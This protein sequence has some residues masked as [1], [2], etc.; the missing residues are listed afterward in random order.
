MVLKWA[1]RQLRPCAPDVDARGHEAVEV[2]LSVGR[3]V[4][5]GVGRLIVLQCGDLH[6]RPA[7]LA[8]SVGAADASTG[9]LRGQVV[10]QRST[11]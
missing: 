2:T 11:G 9:L 10:R 7:G 6:L 5:R 8:H 3:K 1:T 4:E